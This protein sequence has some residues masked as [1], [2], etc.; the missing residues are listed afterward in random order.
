MSYGIFWMK[1]INK[2][3]DLRMKKNIAIL[4]GINVGGRRKILMNE[5]KEMFKELG[6]RE[7]HTY[8]QSGNVIF[9]SV[10]VA[11]EQ[12]LSQIIEEAI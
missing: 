1:S 10:K 11:S 6:F 2:I 9:N 3:I 12:E 4:R 7:V 8:I 5:L